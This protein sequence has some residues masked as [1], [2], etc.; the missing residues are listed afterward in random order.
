MVIVIVIYAVLHFQLATVEK[1]KVNVNTMNLNVLALGRIVQSIPVF[2]KLESPVYWNALDNIDVSFEMSDVHIQIDKFHL[3]LTLAITASKNIEKV[4]VDTHVQLSRNMMKVSPA[5]HNDT[6]KHILGFVTK[7]NEI[8]TFVLKSEHQSLFNYIPLPQHMI[9]FILNAY[10]SYNIVHNKHLLNNI[11]QH[12]L[13][14]ITIRV[15]ERVEPLKYQLASL[16]QVYGNEK[17]LLIFSHSA[18]NPQIFE[19][20]QSVI[21]FSPFVQIVFPYSAAIHYPHFPSK[22]DINIPDI[23]DSFNRSR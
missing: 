18:L 1:H 2:P 13:V 4:L 19:L 20:L 6:L 10:N 23:R 7:L 9:I 17:C 3:L 15:H 16:K 22:Y 12:Q 14:P 21:D 8:K 11:S 5:T